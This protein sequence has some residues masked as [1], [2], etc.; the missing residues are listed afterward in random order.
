[1]KIRLN[2]SEHDYFT[3]REYEIAKEVIASLKEDSGLL[4]YASMAARLV[5]DMT[6]ITVDATVCKNSRVRNRYTDDSY[7]IDVWIEILARGCIN[8][9]MAY[10]EIGVCLTDVWDICPTNHEDILRQMFV[11]KYIR[12]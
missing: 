5:G 1:M 12:Q 4:E 3:V 6:V 7:D 2:K 10:A 9:K 11:E 8:G